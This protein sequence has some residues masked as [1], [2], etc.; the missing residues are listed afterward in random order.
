VGVAGGLFVVA[1]DVPALSTFVGA[2]SES[3]KNRQICRF[4][5]SDLGLWGWVGQICWFFVFCAAS[6]PAQG[7]C[8]GRRRL[9]RPQPIVATV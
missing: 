6:P 5:S 4:H 1:E 8:T 2:A 3:T 7:P 9:A